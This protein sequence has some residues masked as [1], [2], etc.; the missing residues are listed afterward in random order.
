MLCPGTQRRPFR[1]LAEINERKKGTHHLRPSGRS[2]ISTSIMAHEQP[3][4]FYSFC[5]GPCSAKHTKKMG[6]AVNASQPSQSQT[7]THPKQPGAKR[8]FHKQN[9]SRTL[10]AGMGGT[11]L[12]APREAT[13]LF[14]SS[15]GPSGQRN[16]Q[17]LTAGPQ[18]VRS[19]VQGHGEV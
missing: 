8:L 3:R 2:S 16:K 12:A 4:P 13:L 15:W 10:T 1:A 18:G 17:A 5:R 7:P 14:H 19:N 9:G 11:C 6:P